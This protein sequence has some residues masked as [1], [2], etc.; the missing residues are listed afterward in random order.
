[1]GAR[2]NSRGMYPNGRK[3]GDGLFVKGLHAIYQH[4][5]YRALSIQ[6]RAFLWDF[7]STYNL[8]N[9]G[10]LSA[11]EGVMGE[12]GYSRY[13]CYRL[14]NELLKHDWIEVT[15]HPRF[16]RDPYLYRLTW[17]DLNEW[18][19]PPYIDDGIRRKAWKSLR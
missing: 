19:G 14:R 13:Q 5:D 8:K 2:A 11:S 1:M 4:P 3:K 16:P 15:R 12:F 10:N 6:A 17:L 18:S 7:A 9:N